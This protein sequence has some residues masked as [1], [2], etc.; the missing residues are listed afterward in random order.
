MPTNRWVFVV[1]CTAFVNGRYVLS[2]FVDGVNVAES[3]LPAG[4]TSPSAFECGRLVVGPAV[5]STSC[6]GALTP[7]SFGGQ[8]DDVRVYNR[9]LSDEE[10]ATL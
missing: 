2:L 8:A 9:P 3:V 10:I 7:T 1:G 4:V 6:R 5:S